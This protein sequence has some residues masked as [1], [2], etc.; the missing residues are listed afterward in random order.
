V[1]FI[2]VAAIE[3]VRDNWFPGDSHY[4]RF[5]ITKRLKA[6]EWIEQEILKPLNCYPMIDGQG[7]FTIKAFRPPLAAIE[8][9]QSFSEDNIVDMPKWAGNL[10]SVVNEVECF[11]DYDEIDDQYDSEVYYIDST[12]LNNRGPGK[13]PISIKSKG[14]HTSH[15]PGSI[16]GRA[17]DIMLT[18]KN[19]I[20][21]RFSTPPVSIN[22]KTFFSR[23][24]SEAGDVVPVTH[25]LLPDLVSGTR[26]L[27][28]ERV[29]IINRAVDWKRG[30]VTLD[31]LNTG[32]NKS[33]YGV[34]SPCMTVTVGTSATQF[35][36]S[37]ADAAKYALY[38]TPEIQVQDAH[39]RVKTAAQTLLTVNAGTGV[40]TCDNLGFTPAAG[41]IVSFANYD[42]VTAQQKLW[43]WLA[44][45]SNK[46]GA[47]ND[48][49]HLIVP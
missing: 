31:L 45:S 43:D 35:T 19:R 21:G 42:S 46:L 23:W 26:G 44:D 17:N 24:L 38:T 47:G 8:T 7:R 48:D 32:F 49:A 2:N 40:C 3:A 27:S 30:V 5:T 37:V 20:F 14:F 22:I 36:V 10:D 11:Y 4:M 1:S 6:K 33:L 34:I 18:R 16:N 39:G 12:S 41:D 15:S 29:E 25:A 9:V 28:E 13:K